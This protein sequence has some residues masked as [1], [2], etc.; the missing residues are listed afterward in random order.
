MKKKCL[1]ISVTETSFLC[2]LLKSIY[3]ISG[4]KLI[5]VRVKF[6]ISMQF[7]STSYTLYPAN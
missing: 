4:K 7:Y 5:R 2:G 3:D 1:V 6:E